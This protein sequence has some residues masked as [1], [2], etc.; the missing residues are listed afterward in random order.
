MASTATPDKTASPK[1]IAPRED[2]ARHLRNAIEKGGQLKNLRLRNGED[3]DDARGHKLIWV[4]DATDLLNQMFDSPGAADFF[5]DWVGKVYPEYADLG[6]FIEQ[7]SAEIDHRIDRLRTVLKRVEQLPTAVSTGAETKMPQDPQTAHQTAHQP[8]PSPPA[9]QKVLL[10]SASDAVAQF[11]Q[12]LGVATIAADSGNGL[13][14]TLEAAGGV[15]F[16]V[17][18]INAAEP[19]DAGRMFKLGYTAGK[20]GARRTCLLHAG[21]DQSLAANMHGMTQ[22]HLDTGGGWQL[23]LARQMKRSGCEVDLNRLA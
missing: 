22:I 17:I 19:L 5:N 20:L 23:H 9:S 21:A 16:A 1:L 3:L 15:G 8:P 12:Q 14:E 4:Q 6:N 2:A 7:F 18:A 13:I 11:M 10:V